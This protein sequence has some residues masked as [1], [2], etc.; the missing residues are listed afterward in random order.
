QHAGLLAAD[1]SLAQL[2]GLLLNV[3]LLHRHREAELA[4]VGG[5]G[6]ALVGKLVAQALSFEA[7][8]AQVE[9]GLAHGLGGAAP[10]VEQLLVVELGQGRGRE[11][12]VEL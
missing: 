8:G 4:A 6:L 5:A 1:V 3:A 7:G 11:V 2:T 12:F 9:L 10:D